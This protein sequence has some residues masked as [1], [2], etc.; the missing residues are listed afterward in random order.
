M[1]AP[2]KHV[3]PSGEDDDDAGHHHLEVLIPLQDYDP[4]IDDLEDKH[5]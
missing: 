5:A 3:E 2:S 1:G 4:I